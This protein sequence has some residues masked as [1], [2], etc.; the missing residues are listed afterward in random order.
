[1][2]KFPPAKVME[3]YH[4]RILNI[5]NYPWFVLAIPFF[6]K[7]NDCQDSSFE[8]LARDMDI[9]YKSV[10]LNENILF[11][12]LKNIFF[13]CKTFLILLFNAKVKIN[14]NRLCK[15]EVLIVDYFINKKSKQTILKNIYKQN[16]NFNLWIV[17]SGQGYDREL[18][19]YTIFEL[20]YFLSLVFRSIFYIPL[21]EIGIDKWF[22][23]VART[24]NMF[25]AFKYFLAG[26][27]IKKNNL[28]ELHLLFEDQLRD[29]M[30]IQDNKIVDVFGYIHTSLI[31]QWRLNKFYS[32]SDVFLPNKLIFVNEYSCK[33]H[34]EKKFIDCKSEILIKDFN[35]QKLGNINK[36]NFKHKY[37]NKINYPF[38]ILIFLPNIESLSIELFDLCKDLGNY[39]IDSK[40]ILYPHPNLGLYKECKFIDNK[41]KMNK[42]KD[43][44]ISSHRTNIGFQL[45]LEGFNVIYYGSDKYSSYIP[46][47]QNYIPIKYVQN[48]NELKV[49]ISD[50][51]KKR[52]N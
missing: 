45:Y 4:S 29:R 9:N 32:K 47:D 38:N 44:L 33:I 7:M 43:I 6:S 14:N 10:N 40:I 50:N 21:K 23:E 5:E 49:F 46:Y 3:F 20:F 51:I 8:Y 27:D 22:L 11:S 34:L 19:N 35:N 37:I 26:N 12:F 24:L 16:K 25:Y 28:R 42:K 1:M 30:I 17:N 39:Y 15:E 48:K 41:Y 18:N 36:D 13:G 52:D 31:H 2:K